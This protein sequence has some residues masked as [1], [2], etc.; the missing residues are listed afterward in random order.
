MS[1]RWRISL[2][3]QFLLGVVLVALPVW[4]TALILLERVDKSTQT[5]EG[6]LLNASEVSQ[7]LS[8][9]QSGVKEYERATLQAKVVQDEGLKEIAQNKRK[10]LL[11]S[12]SWLEKEYALWLEVA[13]W[14]Q[15]RLLIEQSDL[16]QDMTSLNQGFNA[17]RNELALL[18]KARTAWLS[19]QLEQEK[20]SIAVIERDVIWLGGG[21]LLLSLL[22]GAT[23]MR[24]IQ[25]KL[26]SVT[27]A[28]AEIG[29]GKWEHG[30]AIQGPR[31][32][33]ALGEKLEWMRSQL[34]RLEQEKSTLMGHVTHELKTPL[35][36][37]VESTELLLDEVVGPINAKQ[38]EV[39]AI[40]QRSIARLRAM[41]ESLLTY[42][43][44]RQPAQAE[45]FNLSK[46]VASIFDDFSEQIQ[47]RNLKVI[48]EEAKESKALYC[49]K[50]KVKIVL[51][52]LLS[53]AVKYSPTEGEVTCCWRMEST[54]TCLIEVKDQGRGLA[55]ED[56]QNIWSPFF[57]GAESNKDSS[58]LGLAIAWEAAMALGA[59]LDVIDNQPTGCIF[60]LRLLLES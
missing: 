60:Q 47:S 57:K 18:D 25:Q 2:S 50:E 59:E 16:E 43:A 27:Q 3:N 51:T 58:G 21:I 15:L 7:R 26:L 55:I 52:Q 34:V 28:I 38:R 36:G 9:L 39:L 29:E 1:H 45:T 32:L 40:N 24:N 8:Q 42:S 17:L 35:T 12:L 11:E 41:I 44:S 33:Y 6:F 13:K 10:S 30:V 22:L 4:I 46:L 19:E 5:F 23:F 49:D 37:I 53:N 48:I 14:Q 20:Q 54:N 56:K 31:E